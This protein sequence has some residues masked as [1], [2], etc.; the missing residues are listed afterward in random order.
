MLIQGFTD[1]NGTQAGD[2]ASSIVDRW[3]PRRTVSEHGITGSE[4]NRLIGAIRFMKLH[5]PRRSGMWWLSTDRGTPRN[6]IRDI[7]KRIT[8]LQREH[9]LPTYSALAFEVGGGLHAHIVFIGNPAIADALR[10]A[11]GFCEALKSE[12]AVAP[13]YD[14]EGLA[15]RYLVKERTQQAG[16]RRSHLLG[17]RIKKSHR[18]AGGGDSVRLSH[19]LDRDT[20]DAGFVVPWI[21]TYASGADARKSYSPRATQR[22]GKTAPRTAHQ[23]LLLPEFGR[24]VA[25]LRDFGGGIMT[26][27]VA[28]E[29]EFYRKRLGLSERQIGDLA[30][31]SQGHYANAIRGHDP[32]SA[33]AV[34]R[35]RRVLLSSESPGPK[36]AA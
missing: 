2:T 8:R 18:L 9:N 14:A 20:F 15:H 4:V 11:E 24:P 3:K 5:Q 30:G 22:L 36:P 26:P 29:I 33:K 7:W 16:Y 28:V 19:E 35:L 23:L 21:R 31:I 17:G 1:P 10:R 25:R 6:I 27:A 32:I 13:A 12:K 34:S